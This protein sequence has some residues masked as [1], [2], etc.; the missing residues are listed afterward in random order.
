MLILIRLTVFILKFL[1]LG[2]ICLFF[3]EDLKLTQSAGTMYYVYAGVGITSFI[4][5]LFFLLG[6]RM[7]WLFIFI[8]S[9][10]LYITMYNTA[11]GIAEIHRSNNLKDRYFKDETTFFARMGDVVNYLAKDKEH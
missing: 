10:F 1:A 2:V 5:L 6:R 7:L 8:G 9:T 11:P 4:S 3:I